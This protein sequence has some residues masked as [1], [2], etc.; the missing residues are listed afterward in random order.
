MAAEKGQEV[1][2]VVKPYID[3]I[4]DRLQQLDKSYP[5]KSTFAQFKDFTHRIKEAF[6][7]P[8]HSYAANKLANSAIEQIDN[9]QKNP[10]N[11]PSSEQVT[12]KLYGAWNTFR[13]SFFGESFLGSDYEQQEQQK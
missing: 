4:S 3:E 12:G 10:E 9:V 6:L 8:Q 13:H 2:E 1:K 7:H 5:E 11:I